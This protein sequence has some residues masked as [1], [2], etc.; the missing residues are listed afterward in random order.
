[1]KDEA[2]KDLREYAKRIQKFI[3]L[4]ESGKIKCHRVK[5]L[6]SS[7]RHSKY[8]T[9]QAQIINNEVIYKAIKI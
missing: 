2:L 5:K 1:M 3:E 4:A 7:N 8:D 6:P 9:W